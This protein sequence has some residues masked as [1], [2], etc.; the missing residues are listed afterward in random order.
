[1]AVA[2]NHPSS[3]DLEAFALGTLNNPSPATAVEAHVANCRTCQERA[4]SIS[5]DSLV[6]LLQ[7]VRSRGRSQVETLGG[8][9]APTPMA[10]LATI[11]GCPPTEPPGRETV[12]GL[13]ADLLRHERYRVVR[14]LGEGGMGSVYEAEHRV[15]Q[16]PVAL[17]VIRHAYTDRPGAVERFQR[18][19]RAAAR[20]THPNIVTA[21][22]AE[23][24]GATHFLV[25]EYVEGITLARL[26]QERGPLPVAEACAYVRQAALGL[27]HAHERG[28]V[29]RDIKPGNLILV[30]SPAASAPGVVKVLDFGLAVLTAERGGGLTDTNV[31]MGTPDYMAPEQAEDARRADIRADVYSLGC[32]LYHL[33]TGQTPYAATTALLKLL[34]HREQPVPSVRRARPEVPAALAGVLERML[35]KK[36]ADRYQTPGEVAAALE[37]FTQPPARPARQ[38]RS[39]VAALGLAA[40][41]GGL[42]AGAVIYRIQT[43]A[44]ELVITTA[45][46]DVEVVVKQGGKLIDIIDTK[47]NN[48]LR[49][50]SGVYELELKGKPTGLKLDLTHATLM[51]DQMVIAKIERLLKPSPPEPEPHVSLTPPQPV[52]TALQLLHHVRAPRPFDHVRTLSVARDGHLFAAEVN[53]KGKLSQIAV[54]DGKTGKERYRVDGWR[55][56]F[57]PDGKGLFAI[58]HRVGSAPWSCSLHEAATGKLLRS[59]DFDVAPQGF[60]LLPDNQHVVI[61]TAR[62]EAHL[63]DLETT[64]I[65][66]SWRHEGFH[67]PMEPGGGTDDGRIFFLRPAGSAKIIAWDIQKN[68]P[69]TE[70]PHLL[71]YPSFHLLPGNKQAIVPAA[72]LGEHLLLDIA[73]GKVSP[74]PKNRSWPPFVTGGFSARFDIRI[75]LIGDS[76][77]KVCTFDYLTGRETAALQL[78]DGEKLKGGDGIALSPEGRYGCVQTQSSIY[79]LRLVQASP[80]AK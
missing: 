70:F 54:W 7:R 38:R 32:T 9:A 10:P 80:A 42:L 8:A 27:Q 78:P 2:E 23:H 3:A 16:R 61:W 26:V 17:K 58:D 66:H 40:L 18:E 63:C 48:R 55:G 13:P 64:E 45:G 5:G 53:R 67:L 52:T 12:A 31:V 35:A 21:Y 69:S 14:L 37:P 46:D 39:L 75:N 4:A 11:D 73:D 68:R 51:R 59:F 49:L 76:N 79:F 44:G 65:R 57:T 56:Q 50:H 15:M 41:L 62:R 71:K 30:A 29:H 43:D 36:P 6:A 60:C 28:M 77:G 25:M 34:A 47:T 72:Q 1:M 20:L 24:V 22:D 33:L 74:F 19:V